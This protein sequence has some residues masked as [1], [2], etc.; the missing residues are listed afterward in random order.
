MIIEYR[1]FTWQIS[2]KWIFLN[3][4][5][6]AL[7]VLIFCYKCNNLNVT[8]TFKPLYEKK[9]SLSTGI[10]SFLRNVK[11]GI[12]AM[13]HLSSTYRFYTGIISVVNNYTK[14]IIFFHN[15]YRELFIDSFAPSEKKIHFSF[16]KYYYYAAS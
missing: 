5:L 16:I 8:D 12:N 7:F 13:I 14:G 15:F 2:E 3:P 10:Y 1:I 6:N 11:I 4:F 9:K